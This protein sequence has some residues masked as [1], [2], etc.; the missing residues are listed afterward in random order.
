MSAISAE[1]FPFSVVIETLYIVFSPLITFNLLK[2]F[3][4]KISFIFFVFVICLYKGNIYSVI[5]FKVKQFAVYMKN[6]LY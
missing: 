4:P 6:T 5:V 2:C 1:D 3:T